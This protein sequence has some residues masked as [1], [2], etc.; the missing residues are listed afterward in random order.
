MPWFDIY[1]E[2]D[3][4]RRERI[5]ANGGVI[6][7]S[8]AVLYPAPTPPQPR[9]QAPTQ[10]DY[11]LFGSKRAQ[12]RQNPEPISRGLLGWIVALITAR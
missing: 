9:L 10:A 1:D 2:A 7:P 5:R 6:A 12:A 3:A 11:V 8:G 4:R